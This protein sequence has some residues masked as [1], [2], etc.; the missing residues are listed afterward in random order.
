M[1]IIL[2]IATFLMGFAVF[3]LLPDTISKAK[4]LT[5]E[6]RQWAGD[7]V[8]IAGTGRTENTIWKWEQTLECLQDPKTWLIWSIALLIQIPNGGTQNFANLVITSFGFTSLQSTLINIPYSCIS[9]ISIAGTGWLAGHFRSMNCILIGLIVIPPVVGSALIGSRSSIP[10]GASLFGYFLLSTGP[11]ALPLLLSMVQ[12]NY[13]GVTKKMTMTAM[14]FIA[15]CTGKYVLSSV[16]L[17]P[18]LTSLVLSA[19]NYSNQLRSLR[20][21]RLSVPS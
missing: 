2:G 17:D 13:R 5:P 18:S 20:T 10:H 14:L 9:I 4:F 19:L 8:V 7:R 21:A 6:E 11:A 12:S 3:F 15:Y 16:C 1:F